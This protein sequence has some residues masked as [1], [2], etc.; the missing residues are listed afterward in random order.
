MLTPH[1]RPRVWIVLF[2]FAGLGLLSLILALEWGEIKRG[3]SDI[4]PD[5]ASKDPVSS[6]ASSLSDDP[7]RRSVPSPSLEPP[8]SKI[9]EPIHTS[10][11]LLQEESSKESADNPA[12]PMPQPPP[13]TI[14]ANPEVLGEVT[15]IQEEMY[16]RVMD[17]FTTTLEKIRA[18]P[19]T[20]EYREA[21]EKASAD[22]ENRL[23]ALMG[24]DA[25][26]RLKNA[27]HKGKTIQ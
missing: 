17:R 9:S 6:H 14:Y 18:R 3:D 2:F 24:Q 4:P 7:G 11:P 16:N 10:E 25:Y 5:L 19:D 27:V 15:P 23:R 12:P 13:P 20:T 26:L 8:I 1:L 22:A 21:F